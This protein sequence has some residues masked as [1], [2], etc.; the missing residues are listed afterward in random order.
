MSHNSNS[1]A[2][3]SNNSNLNKSKIGMF[4]GPLLAVAIYLLLG[5]VLPELPRRV[6]AAGTLMAVFWICE[7]MPLA[8]TALLP[9]VL[10]PTLGILETEAASAPFA[11]PV[12]FLFLGGFLL[13]QAV[14]KCGLHRRLALYILYLVGKKPGHLLAGLMGTSAFLSMWISNT[15]TVVM[16]VPIVGSLTMLLKPKLSCVQSTND[17]ARFEIALFLG[18]AYAASIGGMGTLVGTPPNAVLVG[19]LEEID[20]SIGFGRWMLFALPF[21]FVYLAFLWWL[22]NRFLLPKSI[23]ALSIDTTMAGDELKKMGSITRAEWTVCIVFVLAAASWILREPLQNWNW[24]ATQLPFIS[25][26]TDA[27]ISITAALLLFILPGSP[28]PA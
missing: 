27:S 5:G 6:A 2:Q 18:V 10:F 16:L 22:L 12:I 25:R 1:N 9:V 28:S 20:I 11:K 3:V 17:L 19:A 7:T 24:L 4:L 15:A 26:V 21:V 23:R 8:A 13:A 14:E